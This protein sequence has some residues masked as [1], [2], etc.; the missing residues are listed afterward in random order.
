[1]SVEPFS[2]INRIAI[3][4]G[5]YGVLGGAIAEGLADAGAHVV[6][7]GRN[8]EAAERKAAELERFGHGSMAV[9]ADVTDMDQ[10]EAARSR[11]VETHGRIDILINAAG[12]N[13]AAARTDAR[14]IF[15]L[16]PDAFE[17]VLRL[18]LHGTV[19]P[20]LLFGEVMAE[21]GTG[22]VV[23]MSSMAPLQVLSGVMGYSAAKAAID[24]FTRWMAVDLAKRYGEGMRVNAVAP[25]FFITKQNR[26]VLINPDGSY[27]ERSKA[28][29][30]RTP[31]GRF[32][33]PDE[34]K[35]PV[36]WLCS[37]AASFVTGTVIPVDGGFNID[38][39]I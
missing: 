36:V 26:R 23:N 37:D 8:H 4:T 5:G 3:V 19:Y 32:G 20:T 9:T 7:L 33:S 12:G 29:L 25:G 22:S 17:S 10:L 18:N 35:G 24:S 1:M 31:V 15:D 39:G 11:V 6:V 21:R 27:T 16:P 34:L 30:K 13:V 38:S 2:L 14:P 28:I